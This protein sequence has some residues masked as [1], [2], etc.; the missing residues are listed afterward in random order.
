MT[1]PHFQGANWTI[2]VSHVRFFG[3]L[4]HN[5]RALVTTSCFVLATLARIR[6]REV[7]GCDIGFPCSGWSN[8]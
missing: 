2:Q 7:T 3:D 8:L 1:S 4:S 6:Q 5:V